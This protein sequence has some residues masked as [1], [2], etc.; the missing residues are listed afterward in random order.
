MRKYADA[1][2]PTI[3]DDTDNNM[4]YELLKLEVELPTVLLGCDVT[5]F[6][7]CGGTGI[8]TLNDAK[9]SE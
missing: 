2:T 4:T 7:V 5:E 8:K 6:E 9:A 1:I 3:V